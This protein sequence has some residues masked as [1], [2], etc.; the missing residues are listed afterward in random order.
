MDK[1]KRNS[2]D[3]KINILG[4]RL[5]YDFNLA[6]R[7]FKHPSPRL[8][9]EYIGESNT[10]YIDGKEHTYPSLRYFWRIKKKDEI[11]LLK[12]AIKRLKENQCCRSCCKQ[13][14]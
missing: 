11:S 5:N 7:K 2:Y 13:H 12:T 10:I 8:H 9:L 1:Q 14:I 6:Q 4:E 3:L